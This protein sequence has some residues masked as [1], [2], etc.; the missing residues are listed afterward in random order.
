MRLECPVVPVMVFPTEERM[1]RHRAALAV[2][3]LLIVV[4]AAR[5]AWELTPSALAQEDDLDCASFSSQEEA[6]AELEADL[7]DPNNLDDDV[8]AEACEEFDYGTTGTSDPGAAPD[9]FEYQYDD[10][11]L[12]EAGGP[13]TGPAPPMP[14]GGCP[15]EF[16]VE[17]G[18]SC[19][20]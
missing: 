16:P 7:S 8:D 5:A 13:K 6:Q 9:T 15:E 10:G 3:L 14:G 12:L 18:G 19:W 2:L 4:F 17:R 11:T 20:R 1:G